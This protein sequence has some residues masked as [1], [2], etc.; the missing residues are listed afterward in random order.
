MRPSPNIIRWEGEAIDALP[1][2]TVVHLGGHFDGAT[3]LTGET[4]LTGGAP[5]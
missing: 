4:G 3:V 5:S 1:G 2:L